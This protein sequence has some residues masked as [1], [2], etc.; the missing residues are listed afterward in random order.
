MMDRR[1][2]DHVEQREARLAAIC[3]GYDRGEM[4]EAVF[5]AYVHSLG[6]R[7]ERFDEIVRGHWP[8]AAVGV[9][10]VRVVAKIGV[11]R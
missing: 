2:Q 6:Y 8:W 5:R 3:D 9:H 7:G 10:A 4:T 11:R 1:D